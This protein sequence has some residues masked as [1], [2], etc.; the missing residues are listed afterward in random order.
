MCASVILHRILRSEIT[1]SKSI[2]WYKFKKDNTK[3]LSKMATVM[4]TLCS[5]YQLCM[6]TPDVQH[7]CQNGIFNKDLLIFYGGRC[8]PLWNAHSYH[9]PIFLLGCFL[10]HNVLK[11]ILYILG[12][13]FLNTV[14]E[15]IFS[16]CGLSHI[17]VLTDVCVV[18][19]CSWQL[20][21]LISYFPLWLY[22]SRAYCH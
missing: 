20:L 16:Y 9:W 12:H 1:G 4:Y 7:P 2:H 21:H 6:S 17:L 3:L 15:N 5:S 11:G 19:L 18:A 10:F 8:L 14:L 22:I 13:K